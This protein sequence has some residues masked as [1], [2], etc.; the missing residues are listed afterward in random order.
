[1]ALAKQRPQLYTTQEYLILERESEVRHEYLNGEIFEMAGAN[2]RHNLISSNMIRVISNQIHD[3]ECS[4]YGS[5]MR[6]KIR[7]TEKYTYPDVVALCGPEEFE[8]ETE[9]NLLN[10]ALIIE[11][12]SKTTE[13]YDRGAKFAYYQSIESFREYVLITQEPFRVEQ[14]VRKDTSM[15]TYFEFRLADDVVKLSSID[16]K[17][18]LRD[19]YHKVEQTF[20]KKVT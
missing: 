16:C 4:V 8:D 18:G 17:L 9:D 1:M 3:R 5:D 11:V 15:W 7:A 14:F 6:I 19:I 10:P 20:P 12:L 13:A 2:K